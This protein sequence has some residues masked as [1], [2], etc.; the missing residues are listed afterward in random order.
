M[1]K[2]LR[3]PIESLAGGRLRLPDEAARYVTRVHRLRLGDALCLFDPAQ[4]LEADAEIVLIGQHCEVEASAVRPGQRPGIAGLRL[5]QALGKGDKAE[6]VIRDAVALGVDEIQFVQC[7]H[8]VARVTE[9]APDKAERWRSVALEAARQCLR[10]DLPHIFPPCLVEDLLAEPL[11]NQVL[12]LEPSATT[13]FSQALAA[14]TEGASLS[15]WIGPEGGFSARELS[16]LKA[17]GGQLVQLGPLVLRT[18]VA[19]TV[20]LSLA[21]DY[22]RGLQSAST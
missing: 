20:A 21:A 3:V 11:G 10:S 17:H 8:S 7:D 4:G 14:V 2:S 1:A 6:R 12:V 19:A 15:L 18:E 16:L 13:R 5:V 9:R 22:F